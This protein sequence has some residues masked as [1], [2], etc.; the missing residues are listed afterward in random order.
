[1]GC[2]LPY[3]KILHTNAQALALTITHS[4][5]AASLR[6]SHVASRRRRTYDGETIEVSPEV[7]ARRCTPC[8]MSPV[9]HEFAWNHSTTA[10]SSLE[11]SSLS[12]W[13]PCTSGRSSR[14]L[15]V[16]VRVRK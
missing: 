7:H 3:N 9:R 11:P 15:Y 10:S 13:L 8:C 14:S 1:M 5:G 2:P 4:F 6:S 16:A 12:S